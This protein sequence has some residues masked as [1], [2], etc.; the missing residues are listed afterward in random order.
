MLRMRCSG[1][2]GQTSRYVARLVCSSRRLLVY[3]R[4]GG[5]HIVA[6]PVTRCPRESPWLIFLCVKLRL[7]QSP[8]ARMS[9]DSVIGRVS[10]RQIVVLVLVHTRAV[11][12]LSCYF[13]G[14]DISPLTCQTERMSRSWKR[15]SFAAAQRT[16]T[17]RATVRD[18]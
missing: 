11:P 1:F 3:G 15:S 8:A 12:F 7:L 4:R 18:R 5:S 9:A 14:R 2:A 17:D 16:A 6:P 13:L 10:T